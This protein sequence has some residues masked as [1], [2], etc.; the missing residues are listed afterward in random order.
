L[1]IKP[2]RGRGSQG[3]VKINNTSELVKHSEELL[4]D[5]TVINNEKF[6]KYGDRLV[7]EEFLVGEEI[8]ISVLPPGDYFI[9]NKKETK[10]AYWSLP[11]VVRFGH[12]DG[13]APYN[14]VIAVSQNSRLLEKELHSDEKYS[15]IMRSCEE[16][17][18]IIGA[19]GPIRIDCRFKTDKAYIF[20]VNLKPNM[21]GA[22]RETREDQNG[23]TTI[24]AKGI[25]W[26]YK[27]L[28]YNL[29]L[30]AWTIQE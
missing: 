3:V 5:F 1:I 2:L 16:A 10:T 8:T 29:L 18:K 11:I 19:L 28:I 9:D 12:H 22:I 24:A 20:D 13:V 6:L 30:Q 21:T 17:A 26:S 15:N 23:L 7:V 4:S 25:G 27:D 14:G